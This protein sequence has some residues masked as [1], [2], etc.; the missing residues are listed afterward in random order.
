M[1]YMTA[2]SWQGGGL[3]RAFILKA[4][5]A[6][7]S[8]AVLAAAWTWLN[9]PAAP[10]SV[11]ATPA[12]QVL[13]PT[14]AFFSRS[15]H[16]LQSMSL[17]ADFDTAARQP[18]AA[19]LAAAFQ[20]DLIRQ[21]MIQQ[22]RTQLA[23]ALQAQIEQSNVAEA[24]AAP[25][26][27]IKVPLPRSRPPEAQLAASA[28][29]ND[30]AQSGAEG[31][32]SAPD[33]RSLLQKIAA[34]LPSGLTLASAAPDGGVFGNGQDLPPRLAGYDRQTAVYDI[35]AH[36]V[37]MPDGSRLE[38]HSGFGS[39]LDDPNHINERNRGATPPHLYDLTLREKSFHGVQAL[40][41]IP[42]GEG[43]LYGRSGILAHSYMLGPNGDS[44]GCVSFRDYDT[45]LKAFMNG[46]VKHLVVVTSLANASTGNAGKPK[47]VVR[48]SD[49][50]RSANAAA[51][52]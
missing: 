43:D 33:I 30:G 22:A 23:L 16:F 2:D 12:P 36:T 51:R 9:D 28:S 38:A 25:A 32:G 15:P 4:A 44:N 1:T 45:F 5:L 21:A 52:M 3:H 10:E 11:Q 42:V 26:A 13:D 48:L 39:L 20:Q 35:S 47:S 50:V 27:S 40:R 19:S 31:S 29:R 8:A 49:A 18:G 37:Y 14:S 34:L 24:Q 17:T 6:V 41:M 46:D 7:V